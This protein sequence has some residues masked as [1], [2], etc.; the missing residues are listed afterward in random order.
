MRT[1]W[2]PFVQAPYS[3][4]IIKLKVKEPATAIEKSHLMKRLSDR[5][6]M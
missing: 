6:L 1:N 3:P 4:R 2:P 5:F